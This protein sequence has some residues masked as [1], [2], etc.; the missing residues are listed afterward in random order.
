MYS[1]RAPRLE[2]VQR[3]QRGAVGLKTTVETN[4]LL[5]DD[6]PGVIA[7]LARVLQD[8]GRVRFACTGPEALRLA[9]H[10]PPDLVLL[11]IDL[12]ELNGFEVCRAMKSSALLAEVPIIFIT[13]DA[14]QEVEGLSLGAVDFITKPPRPAQVAARVSLHLRMNQMHGAL[15]RAAAT[16]ALTG[17]ANRRQFD[18]ALQSEWLRAR[19]GDKASLSLLMIDIDHFKAYND[20]YGHLG[21][22]QCLRRV[23]EALQR[24]IHRPGDLLA[25]FGGEEFTILLPDTDARGACCVARYA[26]HEVQDARLR[27]ARSPTSGYVTVS[28]G[29]SALE[30][31]TYEWTDAVR[32]ALLEGAQ[33]HAPASD[34]VAAA[35]QALY[36]CKAGGRNHARFL[37]LE[38]CGSP[39][40]ALDLRPPESY[41]PAP[42]RAAR[43]DQPS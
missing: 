7:A 29:V 28:V 21:G 35:D 26:L 22:D 20:H 12:P 10:C 5:V 25:R 33:R 43:C 13:S 6:D 27:H 23:G 14:E 39:E 37:G 19:R 31:A 40:R 4:I 30:G 2:R 16:D 41:P 15:R 3:A 1:G 24:I 38:D 32:D 34:L 11:D 9:H 42:R 36:A 8:F 18:D 17:L